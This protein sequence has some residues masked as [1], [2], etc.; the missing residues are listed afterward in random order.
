[1]A[2]Q[3]CAYSL[4]LANYSGEHRVLIS[5]IEKG[6]NDRQRFLVGIWLRLS[7]RLQGELRE[8]SMGRIV[9]VLFLH[10]MLLS[11][12]L[13]TTIRQ[14]EHANYNIDVVSP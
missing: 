8:S 3:N 13:S 1:M 12:Q 11:D 2:H 14:C 5:A 7:K 4:N 9:T 6:H 10:S